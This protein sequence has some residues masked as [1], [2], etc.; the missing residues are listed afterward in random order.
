LAKYLILIETPST[1]Y[2]AFSTDWPIFSTSP[3]CR[4]IPL[5]LYKS[6]KRKKNKASI[7]EK[8]RAHKSPAVAPIS[9]DFSPAYFLIPG[10]HGLPPAF[11]WMIGG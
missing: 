1:D 5:S 10:F 8:K 3:F 9:P 11:S 2:R 7:E 6:L 4:P